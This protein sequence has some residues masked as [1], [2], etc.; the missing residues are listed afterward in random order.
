MKIEVQKDLEVRPDD[1]YDYMIEEIR[2]Q[3]ENELGREVLAEELQPGLK[4][5]RRHTDRKG[6][7]S[8]SRYTIKQARRPEV[9]SAII[10]SLMQKSL[11]SYRF[12]PSEK[13]CLFTYT[14][15]VR[16][17]D[18]K[19]EPSGAKAKMA[20]FRT[21]TQISSSINKAVEECQ[22]KQQKREKEAARKSRNASG[23][24]FLSRFKKKN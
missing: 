21:R 12:E 20:E 19:R 23:S 1:F 4:L 13:G 14:V 16:Q 3:I 2:Q 15:D 6:N 5:K 18:P 22:K 24:G 11:L 8:G 7:V 9:F 17:T 10:S